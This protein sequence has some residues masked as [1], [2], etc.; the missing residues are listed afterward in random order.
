MFEMSF[1]NNL[2]NMFSQEIVIIS[3]DDTKDEDESPMIE[4][5][6]TS[7]RRSHRQRRRVSHHR[8]TLFEDWKLVEL[9]SS[10]IQ[11]LHLW[12]SIATEFSPRSSKLKHL[13]IY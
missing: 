5:G 3:D 12:K 13:L 6:E 9:V 11:C 8:W 7:Q 2:V 4:D 10:H 1:V